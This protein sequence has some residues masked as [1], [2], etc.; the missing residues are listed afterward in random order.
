MFEVGSKVII[1]ESSLKKSI[2]PKKG[3]IGYV[4]S[5]SEPVF[6][7]RL[8]T[9]LSIGNVVFHRFGLEERNRSEAKTVLFI[10][11]IGDINKS[12]NTVTN[13]TNTIN[14]QK[15]EQVFESVR[16]EMGVDNSTTI[17]T[18]LP[19]IYSN[20]LSCSRYEF[21]S[22]ITSLMSNSMF[23]MALNEAVVTRHFKNS[24]HKSLVNTRFLETL[25]DMVVDKGYRNE[26][27][28]EA[29]K[30]YESR[31][32]IIK[33]IR[34]LLSMIMT[35]RYKTEAMNIINSLIECEMSKNLSRRAVY[36]YMCGAIYIPHK[37]ANMDDYIKNN[38]SSIFSNTMKE[39]TEIKETILNKYKNMLIV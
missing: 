14:N 4:I 6:S 34:A 17:V 27:V 10:F 37:L 18:A 3:S 15:S 25:R 30:D 23:C 1:T 21:I 31:N 28:N 32:K 35:R 11:P 13:L 29:F 16:K 33:D 8:S 2:G 39:I 9:I 26:K 38:R 5:C 22:W 7:H 19:V 20:L 12:D 36:E 24:N